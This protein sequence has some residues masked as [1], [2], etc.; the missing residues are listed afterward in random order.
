[1]NIAEKTGD[2]MSQRSNVLLASRVD[3]GVSSLDEQDEWIVNDGALSH[4]SGGFFHVVGCRD[5]DSCSENLMLYQPQGAFNGL[6]ICQSGGRIYVLIQAR[7]EPGNVGF[8][9]FGPTVQSTPANYMRLHGGRPTPCL[10][11]FLGWEPG[12]RP[13]G[14]NTQ[15][16]LGTY[17]FQKTKT[18]SYVECDRFVEGDS[19]MVWTPIDTLLTLVNEDNLLNTDLRSMLAI[20][21]WSNFLG[22]SETSTLCDG[23]IRL[24]S[25]SIGWESSKQSLVRIDD[26]SDWEWSD[27]GIRGVE[28]QPLSALLFAVRAENREV[29]SWHQPLIVDERIGDVVLLLR[30]RD[31]DVEFLLSCNA[32]AGAIGRR[33]VQVSFISEESNAPSFQ[34]ETVAN[35]LQSEEGGRFYR[36]MRRYRV[37]RV[38]D[39]PAGPH[40]VWVGRSSLRSLLRTSNL[41]AIELRVACSFVLSDINETLRQVTA[42][43]GTI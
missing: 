20:F 13:I 9:Q 24:L 38:D 26:L 41:L 2:L 29:Q 33:L 34:G 35:V 27:R 1:M 32:E 30:A 43:K 42:E 28:G 5:A 37:I 23:A 18:L 25:G 10:N 16:D 14:H 19:S 17:Y 15:P 36:K 39:Y 11:F 21:D 12:A 3:L 8:C 7:V 4:R 6:L 31:D 40:Q 22:G